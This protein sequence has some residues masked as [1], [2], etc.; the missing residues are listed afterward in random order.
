ML[1]ISYLNWIK[2]RIEDVEVVKEVTLNS[3][4]V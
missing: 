3:Q 1:K 4:A 2:E